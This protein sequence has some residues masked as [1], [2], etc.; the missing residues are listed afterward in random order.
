MIGDTFYLDD[1]DGGK[2]QVGPGGD[3]GGKNVALPALP[4]KGMVVAARDDWFCMDWVKFVYA[5]DI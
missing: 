5:T 3:C 4:I 2:T 1:S